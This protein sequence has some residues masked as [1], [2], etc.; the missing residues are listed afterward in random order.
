MC[1]IYTRINFLLRA[2]LHGLHEKELF[3]QL[4][5]GPLI[6]N[7]NLIFTTHYLCLNQWYTRQL[8]LTY[9]FGLNLKK[10]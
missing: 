6:I 9:V 2:N 1:Y 10:I 7:P 4:L 5:G 8:L 3:Q